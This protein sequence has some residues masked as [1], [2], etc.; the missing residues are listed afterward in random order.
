MNSDL[1][2]A[3]K[4]NLPRRE[5]SARRGRRR[6]HCIFLWIAAALL[7]TGIAACP[8]Q[9]PDATRGV[10]GA[11]NPPRGMT[12]DAPGAMVSEQLE[13]TFN[14]TPLEREK[15]WHRLNNDRQ[16]AMLSDV[17]ALLHLAGELSTELEDTGHAAPSAKDLQTVKRIQ[18][19]AHRV[20]ESMTEVQM[21]Q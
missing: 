14:L 13:P 5:T 3:A 18:K 6:R 11:G 16:K 20:K 1:L 15:L 2:A 9:S 17:N 12:T 10:I 21:P 8:A 19:L 7:S 4:I